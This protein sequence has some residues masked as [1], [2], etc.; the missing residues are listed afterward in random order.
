MLIL[1]FPFLAT[2]LKPPTP[3]LLYAFWLLS[4]EYI[5]LIVGEKKSDLMM[6]PISITVWQCMAVGSGRLS[7]LN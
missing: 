2:G 3:G 6:I 1:R 5:F 7:C 4:E